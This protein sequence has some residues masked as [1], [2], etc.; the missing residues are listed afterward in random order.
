[1]KFSNYHYSEP[2]TD[3]L[4]RC[5]NSNHEFIKKILDYNTLLL[6]KQGISQA[7]QLRWFRDNGIVISA[8]GISRYKRGKYNTCSITYLQYF[9]SYWGKTLTTMIFEAVQICNSS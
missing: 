1:M 6:K 9:A 2:K 5:R 4:D 3:F 7:Q 8:S